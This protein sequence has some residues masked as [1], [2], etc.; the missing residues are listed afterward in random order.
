MCVLLSWE[1]NKQADVKAP[2]SNNARGCVLN[3]AARARTYQT[4]HERR[5][6]EEKEVV[7]V[8]A[9]FIQSPCNRLSAS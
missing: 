1:L 7:V 3:A 8:M 2:G 6:E 4:E 5:G 9:W